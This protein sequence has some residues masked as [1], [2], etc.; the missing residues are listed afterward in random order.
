MTGVYLGRSR[1]MQRLQA[2]LEDFAG[3]DHG[4]LVTITGEAGMGK[5]RLVSEWL[6]DIPPSQMTI[7]RGRGLPYNQGVGHG[8]LRTL[9]QDALD[10]YET[11]DLWET[12]V[13]D[14]FK[15]FIRRLM[16]E[17]LTDDEELMWEQLPPERISQLTTL[18]IREWLRHEAQRQPLI[19]I[20]DDFHWADDLSRDALQVLLSLTNEV[21]VLF[22]V[23]SRPHP[24]IDL[25]TDDLHTGEHNHLEVPALSLADSRK[26]LGTFI[27]LD[28]FPE[29]TVQTILTRAE[30]NPFYI[31]E[32]VRMLIEQEVLQLRGDQ[33][34]ATST[35]ALENL[36]FPTS[37][38]GLMLA[39]VDRLPE[40]LRY[41]LQDAAVIGLQFDAA[42]LQ[43]VEH[44]IRRQD[45]IV[46][47][48]ERLK[49]LDLLEP[50][51][52]A[53]PGTYAFRHIL[54]QETI[55]RSILRNERPELHRV[56]AE[57]IEQLYDDQLEANAEVLALHYDRARVRDKALTYTLNSGQRAQGR[58]ANREA[59][60]YYSRALQL[61]QHIAEAERERWEAAVGLADVQQHIGE[62]EE[63]MA[64]YQAALEERQDAPPAERA[65]VMLKLGRAWDKLG[66]L[67]RAESWLRTA[68]E[69]IAQDES[70]SPAIEAEIYSALGWLTLRGG[71]LPEAQKLLE[72]ATNLV[73]GTQHLQVLS[74]V[75]NRLGAVY[76]S[77]GDWE[78]AVEVVQRSLDIRERL[79]DLLGVA[80][81]S[82]NLGILKC[83]S[84]DWQGALQTYWRSLEAM[85]TIGD[86]E[87]T[88][89]AH[90]NIGNVYIDLGD[91]DKAEQN[92][93]QSYEIAQRIANPYERAQANLNLGRL[94][95]RKGEWTQAELY[96]ETAI[97]LY[98]QVGISNNPN[99]IDAYWLRSLLYLEQGDIEQALVWRD[100][101]YE[102]LKEGTGETDGES[103][104]WGRYHQ[105]VGR[106]SLE[107]REFDKA[108]D[109]LARAKNIFQI[110]RSYA[111]IGR[112]A[113]WRAQVYKHRGKPSL[114]IRELDEA[115]DVF[116][117]LGA[118]V[119]LART[120]QLRKDLETA[121]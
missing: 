9:L 36:E 40:D 23:M 91:W 48:I 61:S 24:P 78:Q 83:D 49:D 105:L 113:Y 56:V 47:M 19:L 79:G 92:L 59:I 12:H 119:E 99:A 120:Q 41:L 75:L 118:G 34:H 97:S 82:N 108:L 90:T 96:A 14:T 65:D 76:F 16:N 95:Y 5:S 117:K 2:I 26:L 107:Q 55:Y 1:E 32:F 74:S 77:H 45:N 86:I 35:L 17:P 115:Q 58:F 42:L 93:R 15:P 110:N 4:H 62:Y 85:R 18:A 54:T 67:E 28:G 22:C 81:S 71:D 121:A 33:W 21:P 64:F 44:R 30:G 60:D 70:P 3:D 106:L 111:E 73:D 20:L 68:S 116:E 13:S 98:T 100:R 51:P 72:R 80:R 27:N 37:L 101:N 63:A 39:R 29:A 57:S 52:Q 89:I 114:A 94:F 109:H 31:E 112:T 10:S 43:M 50:R 87:G 66:N 53:G 6:N 84:G 38:R 69:T 88:A 25:N 104:E 103:A 7:W 8:V 102:Q 11:P 46:P